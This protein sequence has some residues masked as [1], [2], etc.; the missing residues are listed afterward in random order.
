MSGSRSA[1]E[2]NGKELPSSGLSGKTRT[3]GGVS[4]VVRLTGER[5]FEPLDHVFLDVADE[6]DDEIKQAAVRGSRWGNDAPLRRTLTRS[7]KI[8]KSASPS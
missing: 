3:P 7:K 6:E 5:S 8:N 2:L 1:E 4:A